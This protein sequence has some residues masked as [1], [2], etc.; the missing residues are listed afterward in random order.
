[1]TTNTFGDIIPLTDEEKMTSI[2]IM[3][4]GATV[5]GKLFEFFVDIIYYLITKVWK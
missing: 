5:T 4:L 2:I 1:M 3:I